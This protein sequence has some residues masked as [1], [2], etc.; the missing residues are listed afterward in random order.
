MLSLR[1]DER[2]EERAALTE[3]ASPLP[4]ARSTKEICLRAKGEMPSLQ[5]LA[6]RGQRRREKRHGIQQPS[7]CSHQQAKY[8]PDCYRPHSFQPQGW[9]DSVGEAVEAS[10]F[11]L[12]VF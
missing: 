8:L 4:T 6:P 5:N 1:I 3:P 7:Q 2:A 10:A 11:M 12:M 9:H